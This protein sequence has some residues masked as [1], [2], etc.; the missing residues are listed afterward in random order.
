MFLYR[1]T[2]NDDGDSVTVMASM[3]PMTVDGLT[4]GYALIGF[5]RS[6]VESAKQQT[7]RTV[8]LATLLFALIG[9]LVSIVLGKRLTRP[10]HQ[11]IKISSAIS[12]GNY[13][14]RFAKPRNDELGELMNAMNAMTDGLAQKAHVERTFSRYVAPQVAREVLRDTA[15]PNAVGR[16][17]VAS[18]LFA[19]MVGFT[20]LSES[21][22]ADEINTALNEYFGYIAHIVDACGGHIDKYIGDCVMAV[23]GVPESDPL[24][25]QHAVECATL[26]Q[27][28]VETLNRQRQVQGRVVL[29]FHIGINSGTMLAGNIGAADRLEYTVMGKEVNIA[30]RLSASAKPG[31]IL[32]SGATYEA[33]RKTG[34]FQCKEHGTI[35]W[36]GTT[37]P[38]MTY[39]VVLDMAKHRDLIASRLSP[40]LQRPGSVA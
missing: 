35:T 39:S 12:A 13:D 3:S 36:R 25:A 5:D 22:P 4:V 20:A 26:I 16:S 6:I 18:V 10:I 30:S 34:R 31:Q 38:V 19:D 37:H 23:F 32:L 2:V 11:I 29:T 21:M 17:V 27:Y 7:F 9:S 28:L 1:K 14:V 33:I 40:L 15:E 8:G 24:H